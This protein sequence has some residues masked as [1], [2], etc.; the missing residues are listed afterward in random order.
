MVSGRG[1]KA[2]ELTHLQW[3]FI[4]TAWKQSRDFGELP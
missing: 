2:R 3:E 1:M 4:M